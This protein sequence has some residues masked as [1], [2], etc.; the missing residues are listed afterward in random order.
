MRRGLPRRDAAQVAIEL[1]LA[2]AGMEMG[3]RESGTA[4]RKVDKEKARCRT[5]TRGDIE[6]YLR[7]CIGA[8]EGEN[9]PGPAR[10]K[11][12]GSSAGT[13]PS[14][15]PFSSQVCIG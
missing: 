14:S 11:T 8:P 9:G 10:L 15:R 6:R 2:E 12:S 3:Y 7:W 1:L 5:R 13:R 4:R